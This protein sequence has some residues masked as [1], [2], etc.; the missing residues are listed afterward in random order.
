MAD[1]NGTKEPEGRGENSSSQYLPSFQYHEIW[2]E[3]YRKLVEN[4]NEAVNNPNFAEQLQAHFNRL[5]PRYAMDVNIERAEDVL[6]H[7]QLLELAQIPENRPVFHVRSSERIVARIDGDEQSQSATDLLSPI[8]EGSVG[9]SIHSR[10]SLKDHPV[11]FETCT[12]L[13]G[14]ILDTSKN[15]LDVEE[16][17]IISNNS[18]ESQELVQI[19]IHEITF[20]TIDKPKL[21]SQLS[22]LLADIG[23]DIREA[24][25]F[26]TND[27]YSL[28]VFVVD[29]WTTKDQ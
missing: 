8:S 13:E 29:G 12:K 24:H 14:L 10:F 9:C 23:L 15:A 26:S 5:P 27:G 20:S 4:E 11:A 1:S 16:R 22:A 25:V 28:D 21:L 17:R 7:Q 6:I 2:Q 3:V 18:S 19:P